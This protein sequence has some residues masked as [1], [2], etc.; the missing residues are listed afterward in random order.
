M[1]SG[2]LRR[3]SLE[4][5]QPAERR[6]QAARLLDALYSFRCGDPEE[7][8]QAAHFLGQFEKGL[9]D[10]ES[11]EAKSRRRR[12][13]YQLNSKLKNKASTGQTVEIRHQPQA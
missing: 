13:T 11:S 7:A 12:K 6:I 2:K 3:V 10:L 8:I 9:H 4:K 1:T 5:S